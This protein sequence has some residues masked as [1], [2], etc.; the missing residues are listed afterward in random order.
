VQLQATIA[1]AQKMM[2][3]DYEFLSLDFEAIVL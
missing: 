1:N 3:E 2:G